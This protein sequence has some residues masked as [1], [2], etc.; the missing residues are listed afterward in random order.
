M[1]K[2]KIE[3]KIR[4]LPFFP[5]GYCSHLATTL[6][7]RDN[8]YA[9]RLTLG[10]D[11]DK[12]LGAN[13]NYKRRHLDRMTYL[14]KKGL[15]KDRTWKC[16]TPSTGRTFRVLTKAGL[17]AAT[18]AP[19][20]A[21]AKTE[22][23]TDE[24]EE[25][26]GNIKDGNFRRTSQGATTLRE[27]LDAYASDPCEKSQQMF[28]EILLEAVMDGLTT[29][30]TQALPVVPF[31]KISTRKYSPNQIYNIWRTS[32]RMAMFRVNDHLTYLDRRP[33]DTG[34]AIDGIHD[35]GSYNA[36]V[37]KCGHTMASL[38][39]YALTRWYAA[40]PG[41][42]QINQQDPDMSNEARAAWLSA[43]AYYMST[44]LPLLE[45]QDTD[46][47]SSALYGSKQRLNAIFTGL[48]T[49]Q[50]QN[51]ICYHGHP[52]E[53]KWNKVR[54]RQTKE[55]VEQCVHE[56][57]TRNPEL[58]LNDAVNYGLYFCSSYHQFLALFE[59][60]KERHRKKLAKGNYL[61]NEP[62]ISLH[63]IPVNDSGCFLLW[64]LMQLSPGE[65]ERKICNQLVMQ[66]PNFQHQTN[67]CYPLTYKGNRVFPGYTMDVAKINEVLEDYLDG[68]TFLLACFPD[69]AKW[70]KHLFPGITIL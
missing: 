8:P 46:N 43:P 17:V 15:V 50:K 41:C 45:R 39:Y 18:E 58:P 23:E 53:F 33:Y 36:Y 68:Q 9:K 59:R 54:E 64:F 56:M 42:Y 62:F 37:E 28:D 27:L 13:E 69:Q 19:D 61:T 66:D 21:L 48:A 67:R 14:I 1:Q 24:R 38:T 44:E 25:N 63:A 5:F 4:I 20:E 31:A 3:Q 70:Y 47:N 65:T 26:N 2:N 35:E 29:P 10:A 32:H 52:G 60:T 22:E 51:Y 30:L 57:K 55:A 12:T 49:G 40:N 11:P 16:G 34:F 6:I 7:G